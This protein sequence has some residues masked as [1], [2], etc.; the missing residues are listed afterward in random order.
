[1][2][3]YQKY[4]IVD[5]PLLIGKIINILGKFPI[6]CPLCGHVSY[7]S[8]IDRNNLRETCRS[9]CCNSTNRQRQIAYTLCNKI[10]INSLSEIEKYPGVIYNTESFGNVHNQLVKNKHYISSEYFGENYKSGQA[11]NGILHQNLLNLSFEN[12]SI[13]IVLS[14]DVFEHIT[15]PYKAHREV[16]RVLKK[17]GSHIFTV[18]FIH[19]QILDDKRAIISAGKIK[20]LKEAKYHLDGVRPEEGAL[21]FNNFSMEMLVELSKIGFNIKMYKIFNPL[22]GIIGNNAYIF[23]ATK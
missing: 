22:K 4:P 9:H 16:Y 17:G 13:D 15:D 3:K 6:K 12:S 19:G 1:M 7:I 21:V 18:P 23:C 8:K 5:Y 10:G 20:F 11:V 14:S 2:E